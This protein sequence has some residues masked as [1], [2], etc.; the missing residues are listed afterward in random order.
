MIGIN[1]ALAVKNSGITVFDGTPNRLHV[2]LH[3]FND[4]CASI[5]YTGRDTAKMRALALKQHCSPDVRAL[6]R[7]LPQEDEQD[8]DAIIELLKASYGINPLVMLSH[9]LTMLLA[10]SQPKGPTLQAHIANFKSIAMRILREDPEVNLMKMA[11]GKLLITLFLISMHSKQQ[12]DMLCAIDYNGW[13]QFE[14]AVYK[15]CLSEQ[16]RAQAPPPGF[17]NLGGR[18]PY[19]P[20]HERKNSQG[21]L[22]KPTKGS[23]EAQSYFCTHH[24]H[25]SSHNSEDCKVLNGHA[26]VKEASVSPNGSSTKPN[27]YGKH[28]HAKKKDG[29]ALNAAHNAQSSAAETDESDDG[30]AYAFVHCA[31]T[32]MRPS[33]PPSRSYALPAARD[34]KKM[35]IMDLKLMLLDTGANPTS[36]SSAYF[37]KHG[38]VFAVK[39]LHD[40]PR[41]IRTANGI[42]K[43]SKTVTVPFNY[44]GTKFTIDVLMLDTARIVPILFGANSLRTCKATFDF[45]SGIMMMKAFKQ[46]LH[47]KFSKQAGLWYMDLYQTDKMKNAKG[48]VLQA[49]DDNNECVAY[50]CMEVFDYAVMNFEPQSDDDLL[51]HVSDSDSDALK[52]ATTRRTTAIKTQPVASSSRPAGTADADVDSDLELTVNVGSKAEPVVPTVQ[53]K[54]P[55]LQEAVNDI[56]Y[57]KTPRHIFAGPRGCHQL[58]RDKPKAVRRQGHTYRHDGAV[59]EVIRCRLRPCTCHIA[60]STTSCSSPSRRSLSSQEGRSQEPFRVYY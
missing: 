42:V 50:H 3:E 14:A 41:R 47:W 55:I 15:L 18:L 43:A 2:F 52:V 30:H 48:H 59:T 32:E 10:L 13:P 25:N 38:I 11:S 20:P 28:A 60:Y 36:A 12:K 53:G 56:M 54:Q 35:N 37:A 16:T 26:K 5:N 22:Q 39:E 19:K 4:V 17:A 8:P 1:P 40:P 29:H 57:H 27:K 34:E 24:G 44:N 6:I 45:A 23:Q 46:E 7:T 58:L 51:E 49:M 33:G 21:Q 31:R 9:Q